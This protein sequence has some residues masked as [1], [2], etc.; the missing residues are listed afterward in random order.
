[1]THKSTA[2]NSPKKKQALNAI[3]TLEDAGFPS[4]LAGGCVRDELLGIQPK[5]FDIATAALPEEIIRVFEKQSKKI[6]PTGIEHGTLTLILGKTQIEITTLRYDVK[7]DGRRAEVQFTDSFKEDAARRDFTV[8]A[9]TQDINGKI[10]DYFGGQN[11]L[12][13]MK[14]VFVGDPKTRIQE[15]YLRIL[16]LFRFW[17]TYKLSPTDAG[18]EAVASYKSGLKGLSQ[19]RITSEIMRTL[20]G[21][22]LSAPLTSMMQLGVLEEILPEASI[23]PDDINLLSRNLVDLTEHDLSLARLASLF[24]PWL[25]TPHI[26]SL[27]TIAQ[28]LRLSNRDAQLFS[29]SVAKFKELPD[30]K[31]D[32]ATILEFIDELENACG[33]HSF[34]RF[35]SKLWDFLLPFLPS[36]EKPVFTERLKHLKSMEV[37]KG[38]IRMAPLPVTGQDL[39]SEL[40]IQPGPQI[41]A[42]LHWLKRE[43]RNRDGFDR[44]TAIELYRE[45]IKPN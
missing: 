34:S 28:K 15:D 45:H 3:R 22:W 38:H 8:N 6:L 41:G 21:K 10:Y 25:P 35:F 7:T 40:C 26:R 42:A 20:P 2:Q 29:H 9:L 17:S 39:I 23:I 11:D 31:S 36:N 44:Q 33:I 27:Y 43:Y 13:A 4:R 5:D 1:M 37:E 14:L 19:E 30:Q 16:R 24:S 18:L 12:Q 32:T